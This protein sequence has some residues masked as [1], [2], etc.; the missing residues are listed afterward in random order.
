MFIKFWFNFLIINWSVISIVN[1]WSHK[2]YNLYAFACKI[3]GTNTVLAITSL[4]FNQKRQQTL[5]KNF[6]KGSLNLLQFAAP[7]N[8]QKHIFWLLDIYQAASI[9]IQNDFVI[10]SMKFPNDR[11]T[12]HH[13]LSL[14]IILTCFCLEYDKKFCQIQ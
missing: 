12:S 3:I 13:A 4:S 6:K 14:C 5:S 2:F 10:I 9:S 1:L 8:R 11:V 7:G